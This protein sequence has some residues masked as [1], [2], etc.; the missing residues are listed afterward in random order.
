MSNPLAKSLIANFLHA[1][2]AAEELGNPAEAAHEQSE[3]PQAEMLEHAL[4]GGEGAEGHD[5]SAPVDMGAMGGAMGGGE[6]EGGGIEHLLS[7]LSPEELEELATQLSGDMQHPDQHEGGED[8]A[9]L[10]HSIQGHLDQSPAASPEAPAEP[11]KMAALGMI[12]S[13]AY[14]EGFINQALHH[15]ANVK[16]AVDLYDQAL[17]QTIEAMNKTAARGLAARFTKGVSNAYKGAKKSVSSAAKKTENFVKKNKVP[18]IGSAIGGAIGGAA[19]E[20]LTAAGTF[21][22]SKDDEKTAAYCEGI[23]K[24]ALEYGFDHS[25]AVALV[26]Q[27]LDKVAAGKSSA[28][29]NAVKHLKDSYSGAVKGAKKYVNKNPL[30]AGAAGGLAAGAGGMYAA[31]KLS[32]K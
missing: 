2:R 5:E 27:S 8:V 3:A 14:I 17:T 10:A 20:K 15:G 25:E 4:G 23:Y 11:E 19:A 21:K 28:I 26:E 18:M 1:K 22:K 16:Q 24:R 32:G 13:A 31:D 9:Q 30:I 29:D 6:E 7:Q 12:K